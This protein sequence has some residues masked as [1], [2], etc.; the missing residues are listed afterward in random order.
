M[1]SNSPLVPL[2]NR[3]HPSCVPLTVLSLGRGR[4][5]TVVAQKHLWLTLSDVPEIDR[6]T[7][8]NEPVSS[9]GLFGKSLDAIQTKYELRKKH[10]EALGINS[11]A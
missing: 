9:G 3:S 11:Q 6:E 7:Y 5:S 10:A 1:P 8:L 4:A 2:L